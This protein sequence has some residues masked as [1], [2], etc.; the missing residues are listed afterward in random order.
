M[1]KEREYDERKPENKR[2]KEIKGRKNLERKRRTLESMLHP[3]A[4]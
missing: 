4:I 2:T 1:M 3:W